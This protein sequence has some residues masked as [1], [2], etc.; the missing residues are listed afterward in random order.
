MKKESKNGGC[1]DVETNILSGI[2]AFAPGYIDKDNEVIVGFILSSDEIDIWHLISLRAF[3]ISLNVDI[4]NSG[5][6]HR[7]LLCK[8]SFAILVLPPEKIFT[9][10][11]HLL[12]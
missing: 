11:L 2:N 1:L 9:L 5:V 4:K 7:Y 8:K 3:Y 10:I 6:Y 12:C